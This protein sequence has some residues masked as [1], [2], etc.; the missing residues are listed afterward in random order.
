LGTPE[1]L[2]KRLSNN[3]NITI[4]SYTHGDIIALLNSVIELDI[5]NIIN[6]YIPI[7]KKGNKPIRYGL[8]VGLSLV[9]AAIGRASHPTSRMGWYEWCK[10]SSL[11]HCLRYSFKKV[12]S[13]H[14]WDQMDNVPIEAIEKIEEDI[15]KKI[16]EIYKIDMSFLFYDTTNFFTFIDSSNEK[17]E[18]ARRGRNKQKRYDLRQICMSLIV[19][20]VKLKVHKNGN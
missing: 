20:N 9:L 18:L 5:I 19:V 2:L 11:E 12:D 17:N 14:F 15:L 7:N 4:K 10:S 1:T 13:Q 16:I 6:K 3:K 8:T